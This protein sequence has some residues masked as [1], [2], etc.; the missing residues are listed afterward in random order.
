VIAAA[1]QLEMA[2]TAAVVVESGANA[3]V[4]SPENRRLVV[5]MSASVKCD[6]GLGGCYSGLRGVVHCLVVVRPNFMRRVGGATPNC[7][8][9]GRGRL[10]A[11]AP[12]AA[13]RRLW[14]GLGI[15]KTTSKCIKDVAHAPDAHH[16]PLQTA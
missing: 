4:G 14:D 10:Q 6:G 15:F 13:S 16:H 2:A 12:A 3:G 8:W 1:V 7:A 11:T 9:E 5:W